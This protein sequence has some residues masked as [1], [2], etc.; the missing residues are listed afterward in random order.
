MTISTITETIS[1]RYY[2]TTKRSTY[3]TTPYIRPEYQEPKLSAVAVGHMDGTSFAAALERC[4]ARSKQPP[5]V[6][7]LPAPTTASRQRIEGKLS[8]AKA[9]SAVTKVEQRLR[10]YCR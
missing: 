8:D 1:V 5:P 9:Q 4:I 6:A 10:G 7:A 3:A 2:K